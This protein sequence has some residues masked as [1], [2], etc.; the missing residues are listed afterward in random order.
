M[1]QHGSSPARL[2]VLLFSLGGPLLLG[3]DVVRPSPQIVLGEVWRDTGGNPINAHGGAILLHEGVYYWYGENKSGRTYLPDCNKSW[4]GTRVDV[5]GIACYSSTNL[6]DWKSEGIVLRP[7]PK[8]EDHDLFPAKVVERPKVIFNRATKKFVMW[9]HIDTADYA[10]SR[11]GVAVSD[12]PSGPFHYL[13]SFRPNAGVW[14]ENVTAEDKVQG[15]DNH[16]ARDFHKGQ[17]A[18]DLTLFVDD[19]GPAYQFYSSEA[20]PTMHVSLLTP[21]YLRPAGKYRRIFVGRSMEAPAI[22]KR[23]GKYYLIA[24]GCTAWAP[25]P[26]RSAVASSPWGPWHELGNPCVGK[27]ADIT[28]NSQS[29]FVLPI[30]GSEP[31]FIFMADRWKQWDLADSRYLWLPLEFSAEGNPL[32]HYRDRWSLSSATPGTA[33]SASSAE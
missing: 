7:V 33:R 14:P 9:I 12:S 28:F 5:T 22:F 3:S 26:A 16:L 10:A 2:A 31:A 25:N 15:Q 23:N 32:L 18:R 4:G 30:P 29:T 21:D 13:G 24:S 11:S 6:C 27:D 8:D 17:M 20:N 1:K 19:D